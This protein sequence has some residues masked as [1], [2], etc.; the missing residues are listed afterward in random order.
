[1]NASG[2]QC[3]NFFDATNCTQ[4][5]LEAGQLC[6]QYSYLDYGKWLEAVGDHFCGDGP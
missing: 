6:S 3:G 5:A 4:S 2:N 1:M